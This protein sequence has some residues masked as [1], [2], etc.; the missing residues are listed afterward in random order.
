MAGRVREMGSATNATVYVLQN[1]VG[2]AL[3]GSFRLAEGKEQAGDG[4][5]Y[6]AK[7][8]SVQHSRQEAYG[9]CP[10]HG[11]D[12][13]EGQ[14]EINRQVIGRV[15]EYIERLHICDHRQVVQQPMCRP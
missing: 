4:E 13:E 1:T 7:H 8:R 6:E 14:A 5:I 9:L 10:A 15:G 3:L 11:R 2:R 12:A